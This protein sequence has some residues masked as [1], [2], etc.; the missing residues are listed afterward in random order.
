[1][2]PN[3]IYVRANKVF[4]Q[5]KIVKPAAASCYNRICSK[6]SKILPQKSEDVGFFTNYT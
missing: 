3:D 2:M 1:M 6:Q 5:D 4:R